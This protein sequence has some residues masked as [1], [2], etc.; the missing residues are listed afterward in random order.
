MHPQGN[1]PAIQL[2]QRS[3]Y[4]HI[5]WSSTTSYSDTRIPV[6]MLIDTSGRD[7]FL[8]GQL[9]D[10]SDVWACTL[11]AKNITKNLYL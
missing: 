5:A 6:I 8:I 3:L 9:T 7:A 10:V 11:D 4:D 2:Q 1:S